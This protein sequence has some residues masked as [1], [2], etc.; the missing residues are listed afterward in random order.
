[1]S[2]SSRE[3]RIES[4]GYYLLVPGLLLFDWAVFRYLFG[5]DYVGWYLANGALIGV[6]TAFVARIWE[7][8]EQLGGPL[9]S[10][11]PRRYYAG[12]LT[13]AASLVFVIGSSFIRSSG[14]RSAEAN[15]T[16]SEG[17][18][19]SVPGTLLGVG[20]EFID[21][22]LAVVI[23]FLVVAAA[24]GWLLFVAP[25]NYIVTLLAGAPT[26]DY[27]RNPDYRVLGVVEPVD[28]Y[29][30][31][32][33][34]SGERLTGPAELS[35]QNRIGPATLTSRQDLFLYEFGRGGEEPTSTEKAAL[36]EKEAEGRLADITFGR[37]PFG[38]TQTLA[39]FVVF[40]A[41]ALL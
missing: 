17:R 19:R 8:V 13:A 30:T 27:L 26:R 23:R 6:S 3:S 22:L 34:L 29:R 35:G 24:F 14:L 4:I 15:E 1:V 28:E 16:R 38:T 31:Q 40:I 12:C 2:R 5:V 21:V 39:G 41:S 36:E 32:L 18:P 11:N 9:V 37:N 10:A 25:A 33:T 7:S 20:L